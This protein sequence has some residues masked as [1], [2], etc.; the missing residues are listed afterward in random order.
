MRLGARRRQSWRWPYPWTGLNSGLVIAVHDYGSWSLL[1]LVG[2]RSNAA[3]GLGSSVVIA[4]AGMVML[5]CP[6]R[7]HRPFQMSIIYRNQHVLIFI[8][9][10]FVY[11]VLVEYSKYEFLNKLRIH[12]NESYTFWI[13]RSAAGSAFLY[14]MT[15][16]PIPHAVLL[17]LSIDSNAKWA[18]HW[19]TLGDGRSIWILLH[20]LTIFSLCFRL[21]MWTEKSANQMMKASEYRHVYLEQIRRYINKVY[22]AWL[23][24]TLSI[25]F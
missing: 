13:S 3:L 21:S 9:I 23:F 5:A 18:A 1:F 20:I 12:N 8:L 22:Y 25:L 19:Q 7:I 14:A 11:V 4:L 17:I 24:G 16:Y 15:E 2:S 6:R 10:F